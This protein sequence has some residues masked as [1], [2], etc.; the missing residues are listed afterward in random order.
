MTE[1][2]ARKIFVNMI[3]LY[4]VFGGNIRQMCSEEGIPDALT[5]KF[6]AEDELWEK[7]LEGFNW[8]GSVKKPPA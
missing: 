8:D 6:L 1:Q 2:E 5:E 7:R 4:K 3:S